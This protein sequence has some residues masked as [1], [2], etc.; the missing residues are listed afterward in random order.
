MND[1][2]TLDLR[3]L[4]DDDVAAELKLAW[5]MMGSK[6]FWLGPEEAIR[7]ASKA[8]VSVYLRSSERLQQIALGTV[9]EFG[10]R[11]LHMIGPRERLGL[12]NAICD[13]HIFLVG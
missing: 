11:R 7:G 13:M 5:D 12:T 2:E 4:S 3:Q 8:L 10:T 9:K 1:V 6:E